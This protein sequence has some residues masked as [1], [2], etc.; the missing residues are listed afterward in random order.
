MS[1]EDGGSNGKDGKATQLHSVRIFED[2]EDGAIGAGHIGSGNG[3][4]GSV[5]FVVTWRGLG[6]GIRL[7]AWPSGEDAWMIAIK[8]TA[9]RYLRQGW[10]RFDSNRVTALGYTL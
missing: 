9:R 5:V 1:G 4:C 3:A 6:Q 8:G 2:D 7:A 10:S